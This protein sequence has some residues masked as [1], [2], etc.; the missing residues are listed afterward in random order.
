MIDKYGRDDKLYP[1]NLVKR[2]QVDSCLY[3]NGCNVFARMR[4]M[5]DPIFFEGCSKI[6]EWR[7]KYIEKNWEILEQFVSETPYMCGN[8]LTIADFCLIASIS[9]IN[10][11][12]KIDSVIYPNLNKWIKRMEELP[13]YQENNGIGADLIPKFVNDALE[14]NSNSS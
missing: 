3:Y 9:S 4:M 8:E 1:K 12:L 14:K 13:Y 6:D 10:K 5:T 11:V 7:A 2:A